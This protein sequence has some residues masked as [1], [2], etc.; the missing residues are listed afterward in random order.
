MSSVLRDQGQQG[1]APVCNEQWGQTGE[2]MSPLVELRPEGL[3]PP[4]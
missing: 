1:K 4:V 3:A 2:N